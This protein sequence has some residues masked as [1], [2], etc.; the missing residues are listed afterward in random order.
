MRV[1]SAQMGRLA[2]EYLLARLA[3]RDVRQAIS[4]GAE[5][6]LRASTAPPSRSARR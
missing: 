2:A 5:L 6:I 3:G 1:P 4:L